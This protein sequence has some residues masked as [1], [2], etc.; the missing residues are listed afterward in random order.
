MPIKFSCPNC[1]KSLTVRDE[2]AGKRAGCPGC[3]KPLTVPAV[4]VK[5][6]AEA[7]AHDKNAEELALAAF[8]EEKAPVKAETPKT[9]DFE[10]PQCGEPLKL[11][12]DLQGK[13]APCP[14]CRRIIKVPLLVKRDP[15]DW[16]KVDTRIPSGARRDTEPAP[17]GVWGSTSA[18]LVSRQ[19]IEQAA[20]KRK[21][22][23]TRQQTLMRGA[24]ALGGVV[25]LGLAV[26]IGFSLVGKRS[27]E[28]AFAQASEYLGQTNKANLPPEGLAALEQAA[29]TYHFNTHEGDCAKKAS[30]SLQNARSKLT[31]SQSKEVD[32]LLTEQALALIDM[33]GVPKSQ[34]VTQGRLLPWDQGADNIDKQLG[35]ILG[36]V[37]PEAR[38]YALRKTVAALLAKGQGKLAMVLVRQMAQPG[39]GSEGKN[40]SGEV[41]ELLALAGLEFLRKDEKQSAAEL[42]TQA[43]NQIVPKKEKDKD[44]EDEKPAALSP[45]LIALFM[46]LPGPDPLQG[47]VDESALDTKIGRAAGESLKGDLT[48][49]RA[50]LDSIDYGADRFRALAVAG[51]VAP[52]D[53]TLVNEAVD[54]FEKELRD[55]PLPPWLLVQAVETGLEVGVSEDRLNILAKAISDPSLQGQAQLEILRSSLK[56]QKDSVNRT[57]FENVSDVGAARLRAAL[58]LARHNSKIDSGFQKEVDSWS[59]EKQRAFG[60]MGVALGM[61]DKKAASK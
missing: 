31:E 55:K 20:P 30:A 52:K 13:Q 53:S 38:S 22:R 14:E 10:C 36:K 45:Y 3:K 37:R 42:A 4:Q 7:E 17:E 6:N 43:L 16:R 59:D 32:F 44:K 46:G 23:L 26:L 60:L 1:K 5:K 61:Q 27:Q 2:M 40:A 24:I 28:R 35:Q 8:S 54:L 47:K 29:G 19:A 18:T 41:A 15:T 9:I 12:V 50:V 25:L 39:T 48:K 11:P 57:S 34:D 21:K 33:G 51:T 49:A 58:E 56:K